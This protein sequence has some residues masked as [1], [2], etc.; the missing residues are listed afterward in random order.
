[1]VNSLL[2]KHGLEV[3]AC[4]VIC[5]V[6]VCKGF[7]KNLDGTINKLYSTD[8]VKFPVQCVVRLRPPGPPAGTPGAIPAS[9]AEDI[10]VEPALK[11]GD[12]CIF[13][14]KTHY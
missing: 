6:K 14:G 5:H 12:R 9:F 7:V 3:G 10:A 11:P 13:L 8:E 4:D 1:I 2:T